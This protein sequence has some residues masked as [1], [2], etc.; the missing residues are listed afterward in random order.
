VIVTALAAAAASSAT[1]AVVL[2]GTGHT[3]HA[4][5]AV[6]PVSVPAARPNSAMVE[7]HRLIAANAAVRAGSGKGRLIAL[8]FDDGP[9]PYTSA[10]VS[11]LRRLKAPATFFEIG[12][13]IPRYRALVADMVRWGFVIGDHTWSHPQLTLLPSTQVTKQILSTKDLITKITGTPPLFMRPPYGAQD[14]RV[15]T[16]AGRQGLATTLWSIDT[17]DWTRPGV[18][19]IVAAASAARPGMIVL[20]HDGGGVRSETVAAIPAI[21]RIL[22]ARGDR[23]VSLPQLLALAPPASAHPR[24]RAGRVSP[25]HEMP[26]VTI[27]RRRPARR[28]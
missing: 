12:D 14:A 3:P 1:G 10:V 15:R 25:S 28:R 27:G 19:A 24:R 11:E 26:L 22:R 8:T 13:E 20:L 2:G 21:V 9:G 5:A 4:A 17:R 7:L 18:A 16:L 6:R 23:L